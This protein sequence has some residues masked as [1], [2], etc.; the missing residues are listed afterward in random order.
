[1][2]ATAQNEPLPFGLDALE[3]ALP[4]VGTLYLGLW[5]WQWVA[6]GV[7]FVIAWIV[8]RVLYLAIRPVFLLLCK[9]VGFDTSDAVAIKR[10][11]RAL[12]LSLSTSL[13]GV[14]LLALRLPE[15]FAYWLG[16]AVS[17]V[18]IVLA[19]LTAYRLVGLIAHRLAIA[20][21]TDS[22]MAIRLVPFFSRAI[23]V[24]LILVGVVLVLNR[25][26][27]DLTAVVAGLSIG[28]AALALASQDTIKNILGALTIM[29]DRPFVVGDW[30]II[31]DG[32]GV[33]EDIGL[34]STRLRTF[35]DSVVTIPNG[36][37]SDMAINNMG[38]RVYRRYR[39]MLGIQYN[40][41][42]EA[43]A[44]FVDGVRNIIAT[45]PALLRDPDR[46]VSGFFEF[47][48]SSLNILVNA[49]MTASNLREEVQIRSE[50]NMAF[51]TLA[52]SLNVSFAF[53]SRT[54]YVDGGKPVLP[55]V[56]A[57]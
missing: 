1:M 30:I 31:S 32:E 15:A 43:V 49:F 24:L 48:A 40:T 42:P 25:M 4:S 7:L 46:I 17:I 3:A 41:P 57:L 29:T 55:T 45:H 8:A 33:V 10:A 38:M 53:P 5:L 47:D 6:L 27:V 34:R 9:K 52:A 11:T 14:V 19:V 54:I 36:R 23:K 18:T 44:A 2:I 51:L 22:K 50:L 35:A 12:S 26:S 20:S 21:K 56:P 39:T 37:L 28:G 16:S 13:V